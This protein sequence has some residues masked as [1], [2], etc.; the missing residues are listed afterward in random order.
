MSEKDTYD[1]AYRGYRIGAEPTV[2]GS[3]YIAWITYGGR[4]VPGLS[5]AGIV[6]PSAQGAITVSRLRIDRYLAAHLP[7]VF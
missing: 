3:G 1:V 4:P 6:G 7:R 5:V 2:T